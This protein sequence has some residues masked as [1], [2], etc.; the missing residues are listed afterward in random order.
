MLMDQA[1]KCQ[2]KFSKKLVPQQRKVRHH[3]D[4]SGLEM[5]T[6]IQQNLVPQQRTCEPKVDLPSFIEMPSASNSSPVYRESGEVPPPTDEAGQAEIRG[7][8]VDD[9]WQAET[10]GRQKDLV[11]C[12]P[13]TWASLPQDYAH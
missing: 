12:N 1:W 10:M 9:G 13:N 6:E 7:E 8:H 4:G 5:P 2:R 3:A 11:V